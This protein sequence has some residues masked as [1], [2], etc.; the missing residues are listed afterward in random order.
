MVA[1]VL[2]GMVSMTAIYKYLGQ[3]ASAV[4]VSYKIASQQ[5]IGEKEE[6]E[7]WS[8]EKEAAYIEEVSSY[9]KA[10]EDSKF[11][12]KAREMV[13]GYPIENM[14]EEILR[15]DRNVASFLIAIAKKE[16][17][18]GKRVPVLN[19]K[20]CLNYWGYRGIRKRMG[21]GGHT[22]FADNRDAV[23]T[24]GDRI[25][26]LINKYDRDTPKKMVVWKCGSNCDVTGGQAAAD[27]WIRDVD[28][29]I[30][31]LNKL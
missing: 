15:K 16:S 19:G 4:D 30:D 8:K 1:A 17:N 9:L 21:T 31:K 6:V 22:C 18:W 12:K 5:E 24:V 26:E 2:V 13:K 7:V 3:G 29:Y 20:D 25:E 28:I 23:D 10:E 11:R 27:K 14:I